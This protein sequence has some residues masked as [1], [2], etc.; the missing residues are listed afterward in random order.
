MTDTEAAVKMSLPTVRWDFNAYTIIAVLISTAANYAV[1]SYRVEAQEKKTTTLELRLDTIP[2]LLNQLA[3][4][5]VNVDGRMENIVD[6]LK[7][8]RR[9]SNDQI[10]AQNKINGEVLAQLSAIRETLAWFR[11]TVEAGGGKPPAFPRN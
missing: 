4:K 7:E 1:T 2:P 5:D 9:V 8:V 6:S 11:A 3:L 10:A